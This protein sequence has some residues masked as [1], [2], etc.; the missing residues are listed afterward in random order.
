[1]KKYIKIAAV[2]VGILVVAFFAIAFYGMSL[3]PKYDIDGAAPVAEQVINQEDLT[4]KVVK[5]EVEK[6]DSGNTGV[7]GYSAKD[8]DK[9]VF[10][11]KNQNHL[12]K[13]GS[14]VY[15]KIKQTQAILGY[16]IVSGEEVK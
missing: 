9:V 15:F 11:P 8:S 10:I 7:L 1:M 13:P 2:T 14:T 12:A 5:F 3:S 4:G 6:V 16:G